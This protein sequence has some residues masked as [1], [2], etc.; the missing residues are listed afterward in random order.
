MCIYAQLIRY[1]EGNS[2]LCKNQHG[3]RPGKGT[4]TAVME[5]LYKLFTK[6]TITM[7]VIVYFWIT[8]SHL[9]LLTMRY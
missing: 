4:D 6:L 1:L 9:T 2:L 7:Y 5:L 3:F 8:A